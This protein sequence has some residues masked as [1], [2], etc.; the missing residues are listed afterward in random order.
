VLKKNWLLHADGELTLHKNF[1][2]Y[3]ALNK[4]I[5]KTIIHDW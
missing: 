5:K 2:P 1:F 4:E 3:Q